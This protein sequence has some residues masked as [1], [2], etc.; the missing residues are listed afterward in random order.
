VEERK[1]EVEKLKK[2]NQ[3]F[4]AGHEVVLRPLFA[5][6]RPPSKISSIWS[7]RAVPTH[8]KQRHMQGNEIDEGKAMDV[9]GD[10]P[11]APDMSDEVEG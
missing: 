5:V 3:G 7:T 11:D 4:M 9:D 2:M 6:H 1:K 10:A 8:R